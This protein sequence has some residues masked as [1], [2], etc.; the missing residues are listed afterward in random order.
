M[1]KYRNAVIIGLVM[2]IALV[3]GSIKFDGS[4]SCEGGTSFPFS[5]ISR[6]FGNNDLTKQPS[7]AV[8][9]NLYAAEKKSSFSVT[10][11]ELGSVN[12]IPCKMMQPV[13]KEIETKYG[14]QVKVVFYDVWTTAGRPYAA[15]YGIR[16]IPTQVFLDANGREFF[17]HEGYFPFNEVEKILKRGGVQ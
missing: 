17:R 6:I 1:K 5:L 13:M 2:G 11:I 10:F 3:G 12:C 4:C 7:T 9:G 14:T 16:A 15:Q 8:A